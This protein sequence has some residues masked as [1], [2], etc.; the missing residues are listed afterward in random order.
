MEPNTPAPWRL[1]SK[2]VPPAG[3]CLL[4]LR[5]AFPFQG[6]GA[7]FRQPDSHHAWSVGKLTG[8]GA[9]YV[10]ALSNGSNHQAGKREP[11]A[12]NDTNLQINFDAPAVLRKW[13]SIRN[14][15]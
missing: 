10:T 4:H 12:M 15:R 9:A 6:R 2:R 11:P 13:P 5:M 8:H 14:E 1:R 3:P 7:G